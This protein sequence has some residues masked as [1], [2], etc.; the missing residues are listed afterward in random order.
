MW[1]TPAEGGNRYPEWFEVTK[2]PV[3][4]EPSNPNFQKRQQIQRV[5][6][7]HFDEALQSQ[8]EVRHVMSRRV[9]TVEP[10]TDMFALREA[11][12][13]EGFR[14]LLVMQDEKLLGVISDRDVKSRNGRLA[15]NVM[16][17]DPLSV[18]PGTQLS[19]AMTM[20]LHRRIS[21]LPVIEDGKLHGILTTTDM[22]MTLQCLM[23][24]L[25][26]AHAAASEPPAEELA[27]LSA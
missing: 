8:I 13:Q 19:N 23:K 26:R 12:E 21:C 5:L 4:E 15:R 17:A 16:T 2:V 3:A 6:L 9:R 24:L 22:L 11:M 20:M 7:K 14:H 1:V 25:D 10:T 27:A 18:T